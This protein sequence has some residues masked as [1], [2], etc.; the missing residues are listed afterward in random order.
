MEATLRLIENQLETH[1]NDLLDLLQ[2]VDDKCATFLGWEKVEVGMTKFRMT[3]D[4]NT[5]QLLFN[6][7]TQGMQSGERKISDQTILEIL[8]LDVDAEML[9]IEQE[10]L[11]RERKRLEMERSLGIMQ[12]S[13]AEQVRLDAEA[14][15]TPSGYNQQQVIAQADQVVQQLLGLDPTERRARL[16]QLQN[17]DLVMYAV[18][19]QRLET[20]QQQQTRQL[21]QQ[22][23]GTQ[24]PA[25]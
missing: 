13:M 1:I 15:Q 16:K 22:A 12:N 8:N 9:K 21:K 17:E 23:Q 4:M 6:M 19:V 7:W 11:D 18:V 25:Q 14:Q 2:W 20:A 3:D 24:Q 5:K 10:T